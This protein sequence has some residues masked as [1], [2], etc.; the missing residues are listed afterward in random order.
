MRIFGEELFLR[1]TNQENS[2]QFTNFPTITSD[3]TSGN[4]FD[5]SK[6]TIYKAFVT[7]ES[8]GTYSRFSTFTNSA[9]IVNTQIDPY[10]FSGNVKKM[11]TLKNKDITVHGDNYKSDLLCF[12]TD[13]NNVFTAYDIY[14]PGL[15]TTSSITI[16]TG[17]TLYDID[18]NNEYTYVVGSNGFISYSTDNGSTF[19]NINIASG[20][21]D[22]SDLDFTCIAASPKV[23][24]AQITALACAK[25]QG[26]AQIGIISK[27][28]LIGVVPLV[29]TAGLVDI[30]YINNNFVGISTSNFI[31]FSTVIFDGTNFSN[32]NNIS[33]SSG[34]QIYQIKTVGNTLYCLKSNNEILKSSDGQVWQ[35]ETFDLSQNTKIIGIE[36]LDNLYC[37]IT[38]NGFALTKRI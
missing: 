19:N 7:F 24:S 25:Y 35:S 17:T 13:Q 28:T 15:Y 8:G 16:P 20:I 30:A 14:S 23:F 9:N 36:I 38:D 27:D 29:D 37:L 3:L 11:T 6:K 12:I 32:L 1:Q 10:I 22:I 18:T 21:G 33:L 26:L 4:F 31:N 34:D 5:H 2:F